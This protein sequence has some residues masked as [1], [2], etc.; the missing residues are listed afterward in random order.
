MKKG[1]KAIKGA[2]ERVQKNPEKNLSFMLDKKI[3][4]GKGN[5]ENWPDWDDQIDFPNWDNIGGPHPK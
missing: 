2:I 4:N 1:L 5:W 3:N